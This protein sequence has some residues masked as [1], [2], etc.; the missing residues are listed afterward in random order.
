[1]NRLTELKLTKIEKKRAEYLSEFIE[2]WRGQKRP[3]GDDEIKALREL[4]EMGYASA[5]EDARNAIYD[6]EIK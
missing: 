5:L 1:M 2:G 3:S 4:F 6:G